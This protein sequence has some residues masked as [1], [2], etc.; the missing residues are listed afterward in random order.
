MN[1]ILCLLYILFSVSGMA[2]IK[3][4]GR[5]KNSLFVIPYVHVTI[6]WVSLLGILSYGISFLLFIL[7]ISKL[8]ISLALPVLA[9]IVSC[10]TV[11]IGL[12][13]FQETV[14]KGQIIGL[15][16][17]ILGTAIVGMGGS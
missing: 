8:N 4:G 13:F 3:S 10:L 2:L 14:A 16:L 1:Y 7:V 17:I 11:F 15:I 12:V 6:S 5:I 9:A